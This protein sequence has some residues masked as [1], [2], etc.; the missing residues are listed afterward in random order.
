M[1]G[2]CETIQFLRTLGAATSSP[3]SVAFT[4]VY[5]VRTGNARLLAAMRRFAAR[6]MRRWP[7]Q[8][9]PHSLFVLD[10]KRTGR[11]RSKRKNAAAGRSAQSA[12][13][14]AA[15][16]GRLAVPRGS[17][18]ETR[19]PWGNHWPGVDPDTRSSF[20]RWR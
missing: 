2:L 14:H 16:E 1:T 9:A 13:L 3:P 6:G 11:A 15:G 5:P 8:C 12:Y 17:L 19:C 20:F 4:E 18:H 7:Q 10:K